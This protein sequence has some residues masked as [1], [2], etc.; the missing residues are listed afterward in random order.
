[1][2]ASFHHG[3]ILTY[4]G[5]GRSEGTDPLSRSISP[6]VDDGCAGTGVSMPRS[7]PSPHRL[8]ELRL[9]ACTTH[10]RRSG[11]DPLFQMSP[12]G[13]RDGTD[14]DPYVGVLVDYN[15]DAGVLFPFRIVPFPFGPAPCGGEATGRLGWAA[16]GSRLAV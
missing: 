6:S 1:M 8:A 14:W 4:G 7:V 15:T 12:T 11:G 10:A 3:T 13:G 9:Y 5:H 2:S 16:T